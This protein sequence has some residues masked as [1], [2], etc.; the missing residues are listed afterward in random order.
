M[1]PLILAFK[2]EFKAFKDVAF[3]T[4]CSSLLSHKT[5]SHI[6]YPELEQLWGFPGDSPLI[7]YVYILLSTPGDGRNTDLDSL[8]TIP[9]AIIKTS[10]NVGGD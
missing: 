8:P 10:T 3:N 7:A 6:K 1:L 2:K 9:E 4:P 5:F